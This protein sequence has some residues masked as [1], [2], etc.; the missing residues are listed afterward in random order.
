VRTIYTVGHSTRPA[1]EFLAIVR[2]FGIELVAD[3]RTI[4]R[5]RRNPQYDQESFRRL[6]AEHQVGYV[7]LP[8]LGGLRRPRTD[9]LNNGWTNP[10]F[11]SYADYMQTREF[12]AAIEDLI[13]H[14]QRKSE[15][16]LCAPKQFRGDAIG[17]WWVTLCWYGEFRWKTSYRRRVQNRIS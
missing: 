1:D 10:S 3:I 14:G 9:S 15:P 11:R 2:T 5:S 7:H 12:Q 6:L 16:Q 8:A 13:F 17:L 4:P